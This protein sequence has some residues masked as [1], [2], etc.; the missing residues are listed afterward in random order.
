SRLH[1]SG[2]FAKRDIKEGEFVT[3][4]PCDAFYVGDPVHSGSTAAIRFD[5]RMSSEKCE[6]LMKSSAYTLGSCG[7][8]RMFIGDPDVTDDKWFL[9]HMINDG[10]AITQRCEDMVTQCVVYTRASR[11]R[12][13]VEAVYL[14][15]GRQLCVVA[16][17]ANKDVRLGEEV[18]YSYDFPYWLSQVGS[19]CDGEVMKRV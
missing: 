13:N 18:L 11:A 10:V 6:E 19:E 5:D 2:V 14:S 3:F 1:G 7:I 4:Y 16:M 17:C 12:A 15:V 8:G 9:G